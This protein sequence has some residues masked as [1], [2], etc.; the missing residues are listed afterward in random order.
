MPLFNISLKGRVPWTQ[1]PGLRNQRYLYVHQSGSQSW[2]T[3]E[4]N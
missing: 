2:A 4:L 1:S 3:Y